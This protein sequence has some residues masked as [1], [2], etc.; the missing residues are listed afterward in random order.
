M[1]VGRPF[2]AAPGA[3]ARS[4]PPSCDPPSRPRIAVVARVSP[5]SVRASRRSPRPRPP[6]TSPPTPPPRA[7]H[8]ADGAEAHPLRRALRPAAPWSDT[9]Q[10]PVALEDLALVGE[11]DRRQLELLLGDVLPHVELRPV[12]QREH[13]HVLAGL[14]EAVVDVPELRPLALRVPLAEVVAER[15]DAL[16]RAGA[17]LVAARAAEGSLEAVLL[18]RVEQ[19]HRLQ[20]V[21]RRPRPV[22]DHATVVD[23]VL[24]RRHDQARPHLT[25]EAVAVL[26]HL[27][28]VVARVDVHDRERQPPGWNALRA[29]WSRT[30]L[31]LPRTAARR[32]RVQPRP[33]G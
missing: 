33:R 16:L 29:R 13:A 32:A 25:G 9:V 5:R 18:D 8:V 14:D 23:R 4:S 22:L 11:V 15:E 28:E 26:D 30:A 6:A 20:P 1:A 17:L 2:V 3:M 27:W 24:H 10:H 7:A 19:R 12:R 31:S 21:A